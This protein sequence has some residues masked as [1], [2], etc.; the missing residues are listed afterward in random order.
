MGYDKEHQTAKEP[1][2]ELGHVR[3]VKLANIILEQ[4]ERAIQTPAMYCRSTMPWTRG[5]GPREWRLCGEGTF[6][7]TTYMNAVSIGKWREYTVVRNVRLHLEVRG[8]GAEVYA[9][10]A[11]RMSQEV[12]LSAEPVLTLEASDDWTAADLDIPAASDDILVGFA[13][14]TRGDVLIRDC[15]Y[16]AE[17]DDEAIRP[18]ELALSTTTFK[19]ESYILANIAKL[20]E[21]VLGGTEPI[22]DH[23]RVY[24]VD[25]GSTLDAEALTGDG[26]TVLPNENV[27]GA[28]GFAY[29]MLCALEQDPPATHVL[30][31]DDDVAVSPESIIRTYTL[32]TLVNDAYAEA[33]ISG[34]M[35]DFD[36]PD[37]QWEDLGYMS[38]DGR[39]F[40]AKGEI[41]VSTTAGLVQSETFVPSPEMSEAMYAAW[42]Y[43]C[44][45]TSAIRENG[46]PLPVFVRCDDAEYGIRCK[47]RFM[48]MNGL[49]IWHMA[50]HSRYSAAVERY[51]TTRNTLIAQ[52]TTGMAPNSDFLAELENNVRLELK[53]FNYTNAELALDAFEDFMKG[54]EFFSAHGKAQERFM[55]ANR[56]AE[57]LVGFD[58]LQAQIDALPDESFDLR[59]LTVQEIESDWERNLPSRMQDLTSFNGHTGVLKGRPRGLAVIPAAGW[60][61]PAGKIHGRKYLLAIDKFNRRGA[62]RTIDRDRF[63]KVM[64]RYKADLKRYKE[65]EK[66]LRQRYSAAREWLTSVEFWKDYLNIS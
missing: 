1:R 24:V 21:E 2:K 32:L 30:L 43:C 10:R 62:L 54:P 47:P 23:L 34:A 33:F 37:M 16:F 22:A 51:Q 19:K 64:A 61:Y 35:L 7:F 66:E 4:N 38:R 8:A 11:G 39:F 50:F 65:Q 63:N 46:M 48:T 3:Q 53:K 56:N 40:G 42:W 58:E 18:V 60:M 25:N 36:K 59:T 6:D 52:F 49:C 45:P 20:K 41:R 13:L 9:T 31:M 28:G 44:I 29:G 57:K 55:A 14:K 26:V 12:E 5:E 17:V 27:G 15:W